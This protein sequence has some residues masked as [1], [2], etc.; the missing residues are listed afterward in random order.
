M[1]KS[2]EI[3]IIK[4]SIIKIAKS[5]FIFK[6]T[7]PPKVSIIFKLAK[8]SFIL[9]SSKSFEIAIVIAAILCWDRFK[10]CSCLRRRFIVFYVWILVMENHHNSYFISHNT[11][12]NS[13][14]FKG[15]R[16]NVTSM[17]SVRYTI[18]DD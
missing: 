16:E 5:S 7:K 15:C 10:I 17:A 9:K 13:N 12:T 3:A 2:S 6:A 18:V 8:T 11:R 4:I 14:I 1:I